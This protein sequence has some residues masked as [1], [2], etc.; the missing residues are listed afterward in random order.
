[1][2]RPDKRRSLRFF[3]YLRLAGHTPSLRAANYFELAAIL[4]KEYDALPPDERKVSRLIG[5]KLIR[6]GWL[7]SIV[8]VDAKRDALQTPVESATQMRNLQGEETEQA[9]ERLADQGGRRGI[10]LLLPTVC[11]LSLS[12]GQW[13][14]CRSPEATTKF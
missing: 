13:V 6:G 8:P 14:A 9:K 12:G 3:L 7:G 10:L 1:M 11:S 5:R 2:S 4:S